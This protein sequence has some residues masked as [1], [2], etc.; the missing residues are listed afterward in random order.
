MKKRSK[1]MKNKI[2][3]NLNGSI[4][5]RG[6]K[7]IKSYEIILSQEGFYTGKNI[8]EASGTRNGK[9][10][11]IDDLIM[12]VEKNLYFCIKLN[13]KYWFKLTPLGGLKD[14]QYKKNK[15]I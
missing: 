3:K 7:E 11:T 14:Y 6:Y 13:N 9:S 12:L 1:I 10:L 2:N 4:N 15:D 8:I 5:V